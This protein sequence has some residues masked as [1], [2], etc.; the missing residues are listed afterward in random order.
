MEAYKYTWSGMRNA[1]RWFYE[2]EGGDISKGN[3]GVGILPYIYDKAMEYY[4]QLA[5][6]KEKND[7]VELRQPVINIRIRSPRAWRQPPPTFDWGDEY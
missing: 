3:E 4:K 2:I 6:T 1:L 5:S 7:K